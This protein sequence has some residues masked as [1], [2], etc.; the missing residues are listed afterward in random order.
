MENHG[1]MKLTGENEELGETTFLVP[2]LERIR[3][4]KETMMNI[5]SISKDTIFWFERKKTLL[6]P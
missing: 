5:S 3:F 6:R 4:Y 1:G 2:Y